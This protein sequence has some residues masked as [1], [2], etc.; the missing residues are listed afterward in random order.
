MNVIKA[1]SIWD[2][3]PYCPMDSY[4]PSPPHLE[5]V[6]DPSDSMILGRRFRMEDI[7]NRHK[8]FVWENWTAGTEFLNVR[9]GKILVIYA[10]SLKRGGVRLMH[11]YKPTNQLELSFQ[12]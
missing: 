6:K 4:V 12:V 10:H 1:R 9:T 3:E 2:N 8:G 5:L 7:Y 11:R